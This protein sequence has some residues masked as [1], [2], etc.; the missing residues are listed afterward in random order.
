VLGTCCQLSLNQFPHIYFEDVCCDH[1]DV[2]ELPSHE[3]G[4]EITVNFYGN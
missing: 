2:H 3:R 4:S 1:L